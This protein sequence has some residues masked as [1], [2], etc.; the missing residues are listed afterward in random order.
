MKFAS[1][2]LFSGTCGRAP[3]LPVFEVSELGTVAEI[4]AILQAFDDPRECELS[5]AFET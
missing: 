4:A 5:L 1:S 2:E 3:Q